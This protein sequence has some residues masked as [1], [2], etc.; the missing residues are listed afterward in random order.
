MIFTLF[1]CAGVKEEN[2]HPAPDGEQRITPIEA[3]KAYDLFIDNKDNPSFMII[4]VR[5]EKEFA[6]EHIPGATNIDY[7][8]PL[9]KKNIDSLDRSKIYLLYC[10]S[11]R[12]SDNA[13]QLFRDMGFREA[14]GIFGGL[15]EWIR[16]GYPVVR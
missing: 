9:F 14:Y 12:R 7:E 13:M 6:M 5:T 2:R 4:D 3:E 8:S 11:S 16:K 10:M 1:S 15:T